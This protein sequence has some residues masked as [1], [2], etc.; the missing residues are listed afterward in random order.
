MTVDQAAYTL[1]NNVYYQWGRKDPM[2]GGLPGNVNKPTYGPADY[3][4]PSGV[5]TPGTDRTMSGTDIKEYIKFP[6][7]F[8]LSQYGDNKYYNLWS[9]NN[10]IPFNYSSSSSNIPVSTNPVVKTIYDPSPVGFCL[11]P[12][13]AFTGFTNDGS[14]LNG[15]YF[16]TRF[17]SPFVSSDD[18][19]RQSGWEFYCNKMTGVSGY[20]PAGGTIYFP[21]TGYRIW[22][23]ADLTTVGARCY[24]WT[25]FPC[26]NISGASWR[27]GHFSPGDVSTSSSNR[28]HGVAVRPVKEQ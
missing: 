21:A 26:G 22:S 17:N 16:G 18:F 20:D 25:A 13:G 15:N 23:S 19:Y 10:N 4:W 8:V 7:K 1:G 6:Y 12:N 28:G 2:P 27:G 5:G 11:P 3:I 9:A 14:V 24:A